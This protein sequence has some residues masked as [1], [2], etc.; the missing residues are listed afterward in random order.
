MHICC[1]CRFETEMDDVMEPTPGGMCICLTCWQQVTG[2]FLPMSRVLRQDVYAALAQ[3][4][5]EETR[6]FRH[7]FGYR[8]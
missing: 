7:P 6:N 8:P 1:I 2:K 3:M 4:M 5:P